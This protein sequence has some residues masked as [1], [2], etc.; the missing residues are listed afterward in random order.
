MARAGAWGVQLGAFGVAANAEKLWSRLADNP[1]LVGTSKA[2]V[3]GRGVTRLR[4]VG[5][6]S[7]AEANSACNQLKR[8]GQACMVASPSA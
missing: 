5:F 7:Q 2:L 1:A 6:A 8:Q 4:A 3:P